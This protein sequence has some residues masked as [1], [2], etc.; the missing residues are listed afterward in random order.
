MVTNLG[1]NLEQYFNPDKE[2]E[3]NYNNAINSNKD[4]KDKNLQLAFNIPTFG[5]E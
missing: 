2:E 3:S 1:V 5:C 4:I